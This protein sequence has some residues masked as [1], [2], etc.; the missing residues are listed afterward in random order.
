ML[1]P[2]P[3]PL[4][5]PLL[6]MLH[7]QGSWEV[8]ASFHPILL[9][10]ATVAGGGFKT[11]V[12]NCPKMGKQIRRADSQAVGVTGH[13]HR[14]SCLFS[15][16]QYF[17]FPQLSLV[18]QIMRHD[19]SGLC[20][21]ICEEKRALMT[22]K[23]SFVLAML[24]VCPPSNGKPCGPLREPWTMLPCILLKRWKHRLSL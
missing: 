8:K 20:F 3:T 11:E 10:K 17:F 15:G 4:P 12:P 21:L 5:G 2:L 13:C 24:C 22:L 14:V 1:P 16:N 6:W 23:V 9:G 7:A 19:W 18:G